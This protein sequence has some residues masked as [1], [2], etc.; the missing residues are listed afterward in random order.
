MLVLRNFISKVPLGSVIN[1]K[2]N[3][4]II[5]SFKAKDFIINKKIYIHLYYRDVKSIDING[6]YNFTVEITPEN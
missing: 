6:E 1:I 5:D 4:E 2:C 3:G